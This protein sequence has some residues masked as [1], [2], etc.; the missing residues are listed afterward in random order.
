MQKCYIK[1]RPFP[2]REKGV[3]YIC[4]VGIIHTF[5]G[6]KMFILIGGLIDAMDFTPFQAALRCFKFLVTQG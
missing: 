1:I 2:T 4:Q 5:H 3:K 6:D